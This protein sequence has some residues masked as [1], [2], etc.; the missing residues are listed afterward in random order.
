MRNYKIHLI[1]HGL[2]QYNIDKKYLG[3]TDE[4]LCDVG[5]ME[6]ELYSRTHDYP[7]AER[8]YSSPLLRCRQ[9]AEI[10]YPHLECRIV[11]GLI[12]CCFG[13]FEGRTE[14]ELTRNEPSFTEWKKGGF[15]NSPPGGESGMEVTSRTLS[16]LNG[17]FSDMMHDS[18]FDAAVITHGGVIMTLL[19]AAGLPHAPMKHWIVKNGCGYTI[20]MTPQLWMRDRIFEIFSEIPYPLYEEQTEDDT[21]SD[22]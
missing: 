1:R 7:Y 13:S 9:S 12:E 8:L 10:L 22:D 16:A 4:P 18:I 21:P 2:T 19:S 14:E 20:L 11:P 3:R 6:L 17:I 5:R 15:H